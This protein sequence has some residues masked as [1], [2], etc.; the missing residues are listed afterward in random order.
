MRGSPW[1]ACRHVCL[2]L[3]ALYA[4]HREA[5]STR[6]RKKQFPVDKLMC[7]FADAKDRLQVAMLAA[8]EKKTKC[9]SYRSS[10]K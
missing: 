1:T 10:D 7:K 2:S 8:S 9:G 6:W 3:E 4:T 5:A